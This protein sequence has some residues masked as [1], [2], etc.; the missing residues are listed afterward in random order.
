MNRGDAN[1]SSVPALQDKIDALQRE[2]ELATRSNQ[3]YQAEL[4][5]VKA[6]AAAAAGAAAT[7]AAAATTAAAA[8]AAGAI[9]AAAAAATAAARISA[10]LLTT[11]N[12]LK[13]VQTFQYNTSNHTSDIQN[14]TN[15]QSVTNLNTP[16]EGTA[17]A[18]ISRME[19]E[20]AA[21][22]LKD[23]TS[24]AKISALEEMNQ[25]SLDNIVRLRSAAAQR[26]GNITKSE[27]APQTPRGQARLESQLQAAV[28]MI[29]DLEDEIERLMRI[30]KADADTFFLQAETDG[31]LIAA[32]AAE[33]DDTT[34]QV[35]DL[36]QKVA[37][38]ERRALRAV[39]EAD[40]LAARVDFL[41]LTAAGRMYP[42]GQ[43][44]AAY[45][46]TWEVFPRL[47]GYRTASIL[48]EIN[49][50][51]AHVSLR[52][53]FKAMQED[54]REDR[55]MERQLREVQDEN[56]ALLRVFR[57]ITRAADERFEVLSA[58]P[59]TYAALLGRK[60]G[61]RSTGG[62]WLTTTSLAEWF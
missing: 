6:A 52:N 41:K 2:L 29:R 25:H 39:R 33:R 24:A 40:T 31:D 61:V 30:S 3:V 16:A 10:L 27:S 42:N 38:L 23:E 18:A 45:F 11:N 57:E 59:D 58:A 55:L 28:E 15:T 35:N 48:G 32:L 1:S 37:V 4:L 22:R 19:L 13:Q 51:V 43:Q 36:A 8:A 34:L 50:I 14:S 20:L 49:S 54:S 7:A 17:L 47:E 62:Q 26:P 12:A 44:P 56:L 5:A 9:V 60:T 53:K 21:M 46:T